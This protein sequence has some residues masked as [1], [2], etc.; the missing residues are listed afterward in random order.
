MFYPAGTPQNSRLPIIVYVHGGGW[1][2][3]G[4]ADSTVTPAV[5]NDDFT[6]GC[7]FGDHGYIV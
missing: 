7:W 3:G 6:I 2:K 1:Y 4:R 5:C